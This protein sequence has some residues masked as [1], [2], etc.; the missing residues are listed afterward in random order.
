MVKNFRFLAKIQ[1]SMLYKMGPIFVSCDI[2]LIYKRTNGWSR[3]HS[4]RWRSQLPMSTRWSPVQLEEANSNWMCIPRWG[5]SGISPLIVKV[6][7]SR[8]RYTQTERHAAALYVRPSKESPGHDS[9][10]NQLPIRLGS[11]IRR[12]YHVSSWTSFNEF[13]QFSTRYGL[14][15]RYIHMRRWEHWITWK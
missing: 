12:F 6:I 3:L 8:G 7:I 15:L 11:W 9:S 14:L 4:N 13:R 5:Q 1:W 10:Q 2:K